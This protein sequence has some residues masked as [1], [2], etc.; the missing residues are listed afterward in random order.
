MNFDGQILSGYFCCQPQMIMRTLFCFCFVAVIAFTTSCNNASGGSSF[1]DTACTNDSFKFSGT[2]NVHSLVAISVQG[3]KADS[4]TWT[5]DY[6]GAKT[7]DLS[8][9]LGQEVRL[10]KKAMDCYFKDTSHVWLQFNDCLTGR[11][12]ALKL[13]YDKKKENKKLTGALN[14]FDPKFSVDPDLVV[15]TDR[16]SVFVENIKTDAKAMMSFDKA[17]DIEFNKLHE[18]V[19]SVNITKER[20][21]V[22]MIREGSPKP[23]EKKISL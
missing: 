11:G 18:M 3:C 15:Y 19:D 10:N 23:Y 7:V 6:A 22:Q 5:H 14:R 2:D 12:Y 1:C 8:E 4:L 16:G 13:N 20:I 17:Y 21:F 9:F